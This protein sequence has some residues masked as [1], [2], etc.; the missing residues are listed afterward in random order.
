[1]L[2]LWHFVLACNLPVF[3][4]NFLVLSSYKYNDWYTCQYIFYNLPLI[5]LS[6]LCVSYNCNFLLCRYLFLF[7]KFVASVIP[8]IE[9]D[10]TMDFDLGSSSSWCEVISIINFLLSH[11]CSNIIE[12][13]EPKKNFF[14][15]GLVIVM[16]CN[17]WQ[18]NI[19]LCH[20][21]SCS[22]N[23]RMHIKSMSIGLVDVLLLITCLQMK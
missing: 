7:L 6:R 16:L 17:M 18:S 2:D 20:Y 19:L 23:E 1:L 8:T 13:F 3:V 14:V 12:N 11:H 21:C 5:F 15:G 9:Y 10:Y 22:S 4:S